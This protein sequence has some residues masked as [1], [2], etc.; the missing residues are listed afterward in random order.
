MAPPRESAL[1]PELTVAAIV[2]QNQRF[3]LVEEILRGRKVINQPAGHVEQ[4]ES[5]IDAVIRE[6]LEETAWQFQPEAITGIYLWQYPE[7]STTYLRISFCGN[8][9][10]H[11]GDRDLD[12]GIVRPL[13]LSRADLLARTKQL[14]SPMVIRSIDDYLKGN[15]LPVDTIQQL[16]VNQLMDR[17]ASI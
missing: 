13:W 9:K 3:L 4:G 5:L 15:R 11:D 12:D 7:N 14:R 1:S 8:C 6:T 2:E 16:S 17:A 10:D